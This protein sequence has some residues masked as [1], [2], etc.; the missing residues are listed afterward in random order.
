MSTTDKYYN[1]IQIAT[2]YI[3]NIYDGEIKVALTLGTGL[4]GIK[5]DID[6]LHTIPYGEIPN[7]PS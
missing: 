7:F 4:S 1:Q 2:S 6:L 5:E 3:K